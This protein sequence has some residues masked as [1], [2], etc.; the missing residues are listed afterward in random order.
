[1][2]FTKSFPPVY[3]LVLFVTELLL[4]YLRDLGYTVYKQDSVKE[5]ICISTSERRSKKVLLIT[6]ISVAA[7]ALVV[8]LGVFIWGMALKNGDT[9]FPNV[10]ASGVNIGGMTAREAE[11]AIE[12][13][14]A[15]TYATR[16][17]TVQLPDRKLVFDPE[18]VNSPMDTEKLVEQALAYGR[19]GSAIQ[20][21]KTYINCKKSAYI[22]DM[23]DYLQVDTKYVRELIDKTA[24]DVARDMVQSEINM[25]EENAVISIQLGY[26]GRS[27]NADKL[28]ETVLAA[29]DSGDL[30]DI[31]F[32]YD[33][34]PYDF[35]DLQSYYNQYCTSARNAYYDKTEK[36]VVDEVVGYGFDLIAA[37][38]QLALAEE[39]TVIQIPLQVIEPEITKEEYM[40]ETFPD[41]VSSYESA[42]VWNPDRTTN[43]TLACQEIDGTVLK[44]GE[45][46][47]FNNVVGE[48]T[49]DKGYKEGIVYA[50]G[51]E[52]E[53][54]AG[55]GI[56]Q[57]VSSVYMCALTADMTIVERQPHMYPVSYVDP[58]CDATVYWGAVDFKFKND[59]ETPIMI[60]A[61]VSNGYVRVSFLGTNEHDYTVK[62]TYELIETIPFDEVEEVDETQPVGYREE[63]QAPHTGYVYW[64]Y[65][66]YYDLNGAYL[67]TEKCAISEYQK[68][69]R[70]ITVGPEP[71][72]YVPDDIWEMIQNGELSYEEWLE[73]GYEEEDKDFGS[74]WDSLFGGGS[75]NNNDGPTWTFP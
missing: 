49:P 54:E 53:L 21:L 41:V 63:T 27:L 72:V 8:F 15:T 67:R 29:Y 62:M 59:Y 18:L 64:S 47:S 23:A 74:I 44:P 19:R 65:K 45:V 31:R 56:C 34:V 25:D 61:S 60:K 43:L 22:L 28:Y 10:C 68:Y 24:R 9:V 51:G 7:A 55:G 42:H 75:D 14:L 35:V 48:R 13:N 33:V 71:D 6:G 70:V 50:D 5:G 66:N 11:E 69:D 52:S 46:F 30:S 73:N 4:L 16:T 38:A 20:V 32:S 40:A 17:L 1:M 12:A 36:R 37:N 3:N 2:Q 58:G 26:N 39:G 57:V